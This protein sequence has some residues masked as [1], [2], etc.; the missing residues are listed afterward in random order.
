MAKYPV[1]VELVGQDGNAFAIIGAV[2]R[3]LKRA[4]L[5]EEAQEYQQQAMACG[6][7]DEL[8]QL[9]MQTVEVY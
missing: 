4:G 1:E 9:T 7:Y 8:L 6:S 2:S 5:R 3:E